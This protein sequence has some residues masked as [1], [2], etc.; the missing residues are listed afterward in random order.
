MQKDEMLKV[1]REIAP[2]NPETWLE[3]LI[4]SK[5]V[6]IPS[7]DFVEGKKVFEKLYEV[8]KIQRELNEARRGVR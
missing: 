4:L 1:I 6:K 5:H 7:S 3:I 8:I 2:L